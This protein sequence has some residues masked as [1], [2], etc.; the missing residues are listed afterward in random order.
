MVLTAAQTATFFEDASHMGIPHDTVVQMRQEGIETVSDLADFDKDALQQLADNLRRPGGRVPDPNPG[1][2]PG[3]TIPTP[4]FVFGAKSQKRLLVATDLV[5]YYQ[6]TGRDLTAPNIRWDPVIKN[7][8]D[9][10]KAL[11]AKRDV[12]AP[13]VPKITKTLPVIKWTESFKDFCYRKIG[14][15]NIPLYY[16]IRPDDAVA[17][18]AP[19]LENNQPHSAEHGSVEEE[20]V[21]RATHTHALFRDDNATVYHCL[22]EATRSTQYAASIQ[23]FQRSKNGRGAWLALKGQ[24]AGNDKWEAEIKRQEQLLHSRI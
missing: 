23:P 21:A 16:V 19:A 3:A 10:W 14:V 13:T 2:A 1:A 20:L 8:E 11:K 4:S 7:F 18:A 15:R 5:K 24:Y 22:E 17:A 12:D 9:Q 6:T